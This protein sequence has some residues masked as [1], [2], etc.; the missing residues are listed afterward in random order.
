MPKMKTNRGARK[1][2]RISSTGK[3]KRNHAGKSHILTKK[4][5]KRKRKLRKAGQVDASD[6]RR[7]HRMIGQ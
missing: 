6:A 4:T 1:R 5:R 7:V 2:F 3:L